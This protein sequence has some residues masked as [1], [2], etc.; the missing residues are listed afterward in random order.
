[1]WNSA[2]LQNINKNIERVKVVKF[3]IHFC[4]KNCRI[5]ISINQRF[6]KLKINSLRLLITLNPINR[7]F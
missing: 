2:L 4:D 6:K 7:S 3:N 5:L 1:M